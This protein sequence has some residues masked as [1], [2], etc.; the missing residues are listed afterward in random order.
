MVARSYSRRE[1]ETLVHAL[2]HHADELRHLADQAEAESLL[3]SY[4]KYN[5]FRVKVREFDTF[6]LIINDRFE[7]AERAAN[8]D[9][10][11]HFEDQQF[12]ILN[13]MVEASVMFLKIL[14]ELQD[15]PLGAKHVFLTELQRLQRTEQRLA[16]PRYEGQFTEEQ[17]KRLSV[18]QDILKEII[19]RAPNL[20]TFAA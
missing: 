10:R 17:K 15:L 11:E 13:D 9:L 20:L 12:Q 19:E 14:S 5:K 8:T 6:A 7:N 2:D 1:I 16:D 4:N 18:A 3:K